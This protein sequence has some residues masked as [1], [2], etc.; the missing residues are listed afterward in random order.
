MPRRRAP[1]NTNGGFDLRR[2]PDRTTAIGQMINSYLSSK[3]E[4]D[5]ASIHL[6]FSANRWEK[7]SAMIAA[8]EA[9]TT[10][11]VDRYSY[12]GVAFT[13][14][15]GI[16]SLDLDWCKAPEVGLP[17]PDALIYLTM[18]AEAAAAR[19]GFGEERYE[20][21]AMQTAVKKQF[22]ALRDASWTVIDAAQDIETVHGQVKEVADA[23]ISAC[24]SGKEPLRALWSGEPLKL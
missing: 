21:L 22:E 15:K 24:K 16:P 6:L 4:V 7:R 20:T 10:L 19:G 11:V 9:G 23:A 3:S 1:S 17:A 12:S 2:F 8:L 18:S 5:D 14:S 13:A